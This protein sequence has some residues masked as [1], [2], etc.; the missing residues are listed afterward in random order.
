[1]PPADREA[2]LEALLRGIPYLADL[3]RVSLARLI[4]ALEE[5]SLPAGSL[6][7]E[8]GA[9]ADALYLLEEGS[10]RVT[11]RSDRGEV[12]VADVTAPG[13]FGDLGLLLARR[14]GSIRAVT[15]V[16]LW[17]MPRERFE[18]LVRER[19]Q[20]ALSLTRTMAELLD[21]RQRS[22]VG[23][24]I[25][26]TERPPAAVPALGVARRT[27]LRLTASLAVP[28]TLWWLPAP[29]GLETAGWHVVAILIGA[30]VAWFLEPAPDFVIALAMAAAWGITGTAPLAAV[31]SGFASSSWLL[32]LGALALA[33]AMIR[34]GL[35]FRT[36]LLALRRFPATHNG[37]LLALLIGGAFVTPV[38]PLSVARVAAVA[39]LSVEIARSLGYP[40]RSR[41]SAALSFAGLAG[42]WYFSNIFLTGFA[43]NFFVLGLL[44]PADQQRFGWL[45]WL[46]AAA[47]AGIVCLG[48]A[49]A[50]LMWLFPPEGRARVSSLI[51]RRQHRA[52]GPLSSAE[53]I[54][55]ASLGI[56]VAGL[57][58]QPVIG[59]EPAWFALVALVIVTAT[60]LGREQFRSSLDWGFL[61]FFG[62]LLGSSAV[63][64]RNGVDAWVAGRLLSLASLVGSPQL[65][66]L[67]IGL[68]TIAIRFVLPSRPTMI[69]LALALVPAANA[70]GMSPWV[71]GF[72]ILACANVWILPY[73]G[74]EY[75][76][77]RDATRGEAFDDAQ[78]TRFGAALV[79][80]RLLA[81]AA[82]I[83]VWTA[84]G[85][86]GSR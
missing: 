69:L 78:G 38:V 32:A 22:L 46:A 76:I 20:I 77:M 47:T 10:V 11:V 34:S 18:A 37:Q 12:E 59:V 85:L 6:I 13:Y 24:P 29:A 19:P 56:L 74:L 40:P 2:S 62:I 8:E 64:Q 45:G 21:R 30:A 83:P 27:P 52:L 67:L 39:P 26:E 42:Y 25:V 71:V 68:L 17:R 44:P 84:M 15:D 5:L 66:V 3:D 63:L 70:L 55:L 79:A 75:L 65:M 50:A 80:V 82:S 86:V 57:V 81:I 7:A 28:A 14:T 73:Q 36:A 72:V 4:G 31:M 16:R 49:S 43:T 61:I 51:L 9:A 23:A 41:G 53:W 58:L 35:L 48:G 54:A 1:M 33:G 60:I